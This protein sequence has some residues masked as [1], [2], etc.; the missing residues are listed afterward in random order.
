MLSEEDFWQQRKNAHQQEDGREF[1]K[2]AK[3]SWVLVTKTSSRKGL[4]KQASVLEE[5]NTKKQASIKQKD[6]DRYHSDTRRSFST[7][8]SD[9]RR[10]FN[11]STTKVSVFQ[12]NG[13]PKKKRANNHLL[14]TVEEL[15]K[16]KLPKGTEAKMC[17][18][19]RDNCF[20]LSFEEPDQAKSFFKKKTTVFKRKGHLATHKNFSFQWRRISAPRKHKVYAPKKARSEPCPK[21][22]VQPVLDKPVPAPAS[23]A[24]ATKAADDLC[25]RKS[26]ETK[27]KPTGEAVSRVEKRKSSTWKQTSTKAKKAGQKSNH[28]NTA[29][30]SKTT[31][32]QSYG[33]ILA[34]PGNGSEDKGEKMK[35][36]NSRGNETIH[37]KENDSSTTALSLDD[38]STSSS[39]STSHSE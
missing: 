32:K 17:E 37:S 11:V 9:T 10:S 27:E 7:N 33:G 31:H 18:I 38:S 34:T 28:S 1:Q 8:K 22:Q 29:T 4:N 16:V 25:L 26:W 21:N 2:E 19:Q 36:Q 15:L 35:R 13:I 3:N 14:K 24:R 23:S 6:S 12:R 30:D 5:T 39:P 20:I